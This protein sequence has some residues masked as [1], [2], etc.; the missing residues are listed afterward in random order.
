MAKRLYAGAACAALMSLCAPVAAATV[1]STPQSFRMFG[2]ASEPGVQ[3]FYASRGGSPLEIVDT[4]ISE[5][6]R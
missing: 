6:P 2:I 4:A 5:L 3:A 1:P